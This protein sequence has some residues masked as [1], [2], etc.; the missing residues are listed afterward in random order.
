MPVVILFRA[1]GIES[2]REIY[3]HICYDLKD[4]AMMNLLIGSF[5][6]AKYN[7]T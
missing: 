4:D 2:D 3:E 6:E 7:L 1:L 5:K